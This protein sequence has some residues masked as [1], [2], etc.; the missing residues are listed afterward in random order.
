M[1]ERKIRE[2]GTRRL[3]ASISRFGTAARARLDSRVKTLSPSE[4]EAFAR[5]RGVAVA[6]PKASVE[7]RRVPASASPSRWIG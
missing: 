3:R 1:T 5:A 6:K 4:L 7:P 2:Q